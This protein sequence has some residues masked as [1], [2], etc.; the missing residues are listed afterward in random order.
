[1]KQRFERE[2]RTI[3]SLSH[4][5][6]CALYDIGQ[7]DGISYLVMELLEGET[8]AERLNKGALPLEQVLR[9]G[10]QIA[11]AL[12]KAHRQGIIH[13]DLKP[14]N[15][16][17]TKSGVK[18]LDFGLAKLQPSVAQSLS[19]V[20][21]LPTEQR[22]ITR[23]GTILGTM[24]YMAPEQLEG[25]ETDARTDIFAFGSVLYEMATGK[26]AFTGKSQA[27]LISAILSVDPV[28]ISTVQP[29][30]PPALDRVVKTCLAKDPEDRWQTARDAL[31]E[32]RWIAEGGSQAGVSA[33]AITAPRKKTAMLPWLIT[34]LLLLATAFFG[35]HYFHS[36]TSQQPVTRFTINPPEGTSF[37]G[38]IAVSPDERQLAFVASGNDGVSFL[39]VRSFDSIVDTKL[40]GTQDARYPFWSP[41]GRYIAFFAD[42][43]LKKIEFAAKNLETICDVADPRG[44]SWNKDGAILFTPNASDVLYSVPAAGGDVTLVTKLETSR[45]DNSHR[46]PQ[47]LPDGRHF[48]FYLQSGQSKNAGVYLGS[49]DSKVVKFLLPADSPAAYID[50]GYLIFLRQGKLMYQKFDLTNLKLEEQPVSFPGQVWTSSTFG[51]LAAFSTAGNVLAYRGG[52]ETGQFHWYDRSGKDLSA[53]S[54]P[55]QQAEPFFSP[56]EK[57]VALNRD[58]DIWILVLASGAYSRFTFDPSDESTAIWSPDGRTIVFTSSRNGAYNL[59][60]K[61]S[62]GS[63]EEELLFP[64]STDSYPDDWSKDGRFIIYEN[65]DR[66]SKRHSAFYAAERRKN[67]RWKR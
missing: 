6:I 36:T 22:D 46:W 29:M 21:I 58:R 55:G 40:Q 67:L 35:Y 3:S 9:Y 56:D 33:P 14:G 7:Q 10:M 4:P 43:K 34:A 5:N 24:Q 39:W 25:R 51:G 12:D 19:G 52:S 66:S 65:V 50:E 64:S 57:H 37:A 54:T 2:A 1:M 44:G 20:S 41:D 32:L 23:E 26:K 60:K 18:L 42:G 11:D 59:Y 27:S 53:V 63:T 28:P 45:A 48:M 15:I 61:P 30:T 16:M 62:D 47:F 31:L 38:T 17:L 49:M 8:L 13:R